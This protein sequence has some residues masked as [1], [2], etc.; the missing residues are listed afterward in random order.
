MS[1]YQGSPIPQTN[2]YAPPPHQTRQIPR[3]LHPRATGKSG[4]GGGIVGGLVGSR[5]RSCFRWD[6]GGGFLSWGGGGAAV[7]ASWAGGY[8]AGERGRS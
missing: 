7:T 2:E 5:H 3:L 6:L 4:I 1:L 8:V